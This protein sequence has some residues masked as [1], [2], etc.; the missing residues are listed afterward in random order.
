[1][2]FKKWLSEQKGDWDDLTGGG[3]KSPF[4]FVGQGIL[5]LLSFIFLALVLSLGAFSVSEKGYLGLLD[6]F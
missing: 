4:V 3:W 5:A 6:L 2:D 1:M